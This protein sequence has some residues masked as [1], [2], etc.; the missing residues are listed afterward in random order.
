MDFHSI[1]PV[2]K[3]EPVVHLIAVNDV[4]HTVAIEL[5]S[6]VLLPSTKI[7]KRGEYRK[8]NLNAAAIREMLEKPKKAPSCFRQLQQ[9]V[10]S[11]SV[12]DEI[13]GK[14]L[15]KNITKQG[16]DY[17]IIFYLLKASNNYEINAFITRD[18]SFYYK[19]LFDTF[20]DILEKTK[21]KIN[22]ADLKS[23]EALV[24]NFPNYA[25]VSSK[26]FLLSLDDIT[27]R[28]NFRSPV[29]SALYV[30]KLLLSIPR[31][32]RRDNFVHVLDWGVVSSANKKLFT[33]ESILSKLD[34]ASDMH[35][36][37][38]LSQIQSRMITNSKCLT[39]K[40][41]GTKEAIKSLAESITLFVDN[42]QLPL[43]NLS[44]IIFY[45]NKGPSL[46]Q[47]LV[48]Y[49]GKESLLKHIFKSVQ[50]FK[51]FVLQVLYAIY[52]ISL[53]GIVH[54]NLNL[55]SIILSKATGKQKDEFIFYGKTKVVMPPCGVNVS[56]FDFG[57]AVLS[58]KHDKEFMDSHIK[59][60]ITHLLGN[61]HD[62]VIKNISNEKLFSCF[63]MHDVVSFGVYLLDE[64]VYF[65]TLVDKTLLGECIDFLKEML[66]K[67]CIFAE[68]VYSSKNEL[69]N[70][71]KPGENIRWLIAELYETSSYDKLITIL[72][73]EI[74]VVS[75]HAVR[76][77]EMKLEVLANYR[78]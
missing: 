48:N 24:T 65:D 38:E 42:L 70:F 18:T 31:Y 20:D 60:T 58:P 28:D 45:E 73:K 53:R 72:D 61:N 47:E 66:N 36:I 26:L 33:D 13:K 56:L 21:T 75:S 9:A 4:I 40:D 14:Y 39:T 77:E 49:D 76:A 17:A 43:N 74:Q 34:K 71:K 16:F 51:R 8:T 5:H 30:N 41:C 78:M 12:K 19:L 35:R 11:V 64:L 1:S 3:E 69:V 50:T 59:D 6:V 15:I 29:W 67:A 44:A 54:N 62:K 7:L 63:G 27:D 32:Y 68:Q 10:R 25:G 2:G 52:L 55:D 23:F 22:D 57:L 46:L 37:R